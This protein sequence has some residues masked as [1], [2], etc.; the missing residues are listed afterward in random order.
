MKESF[1]FTSFIASIGCT[2]LSVSAA[3]VTK[4]A[5][6]TDLNDSASWGGSAPGTGDVALW[7]GT[8]AGPSLTIGSNA[9]WSGIRVTGATGNVGVTGAGSLT[10]G[11]SGIDLSGSSVNMSLA[12]A[13]TLNGNQT[14]KAASG[15]DISVSGAIGGTGD[16]TLGAVAVSQTYNAGYISTSSSSPTTLFTNTSLSAILA[17]N[18]VM[19]GGWIPSAT[20]ATGYYLTNNGSTAAVQLQFYDGNSYTKVAR[21]QLVQS[22]SDVVA[23]QDYAKYKSGNF[24]GQNFDSLAVDGDPPI[25]SGGYGVNSFTG[26]TSLAA[27]GTISLSGSNTYTGAT[28]L[29]TGTLAVSGGNAIPDGSAVSIATGSTLLLNASESI[30]SL[31]GAGAGNLQGNTLTAGGNNASTTFSGGLSGTGGVL[32]KTGTGTLTLSGTNSHTGGSTV[33]SGVLTGTT[34][35]AFG[36]GTITVNAPNGTTSG[37]MLG[38][39]ADV[40]NPIVVNSSGTGVAVIGADSSGSGQN[41]ATFA[42]QVTLN[43]PATFSSAVPGDRLALD[44]KVTGNAGTITITGGSRVTFSAATNDFVGNIQITGAGTVFQSSVATPAGVIP[45]STDITVGADTVFQTASSSGTETIGGL[46]GSGEVRSFKDTNPGNIFGTSLTIGGGDKSGSFS[47]V[48]ANGNS[49]L[50]INKTGTGTQTLS[51]TS[52]YTGATSVNAGTLLVTGAL[53]NTAVTVSPGATVGGGGSIG[54]TLSFGI[55]SFFDIFAAV[56]NNDPLS[57]TG[58]VTFAGG[59]GIDNLTGVNWD[60]VADGTYTLLT[61]S[62]QDFSLA[63]LDNWGEGQKASI[64]TITGRYAYFESGSLKMVVIPEPSAMVLGALGALGLSLR[65]RRGNR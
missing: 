34:N 16:L 58:T 35:G 25:G 40:S 55:N 29:L 62:G 42:G 15:R 17:A 6:G 18:G 44:G 28:N 30:G 46:Y 45:D 39:R 24:V 63:G 48:I 65:R 31:A 53:G 9:N 1:K 50:S 3:D 59:F 22:G 12:N 5:T 57:V 38:N 60:T 33:N 56:E 27:P 21:I 54:G 64:G 23:Y 11:T 37:V 14:W 19:Q 13:I 2:V 26:I 4:S 36:S 20:P 10:L 43:G 7:T 41:A 47:G 61:G 49:A 32:T 51:G 8:S 52:T